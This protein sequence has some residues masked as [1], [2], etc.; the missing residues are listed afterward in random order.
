MWLMGDHVERRE[1]SDTQI[2][3][4]SNTS[5]NAKFKSV[6]VFFSKLILNFWGQFGA[7]EKII[8]SS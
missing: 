6:I 1:T 5:C 8:Y 2:A 7:V 3:S 4:F